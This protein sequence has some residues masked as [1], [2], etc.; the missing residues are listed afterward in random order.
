MGWG[1]QERKAGFGRFLA[2]LLV[3]VLLQPVWGTLAFADDKHVSAKVE[4]S[5]AAAARADPNAEFRVVVTAAADVKKTGQRRAADSVRKVNGRVTHALGIV[6]GASATLTGA[7]LLAL[8]NDKDV[9]AIV[10]DRSF[11][12]TF[13]PVAG[14]AATSSAPLAEIGAPATWS[15]LGLTG[16]GVTVAV[17][18]SGVAAHPDLGSRLVAAIDFTSSAPT[19]SPVAL[20]DPG[21]HGTHVAGLV[22]GD[23]TASGGLY[24]GVAPNASVVD[25]RVI[26]A[27]GTT[28]LSTVLR[29]LQWVLENRRVYNIRV[30]NLSFGA[31][32]RASYTEDLLATAA[33]VLTFA[34][35]V[36]VCAAG[37]A[38]PGTATIATPGSDPYVVTVGALDDAGTP[39]LLDDSIAA[40]SSRGPTA[41]DAIAKPDVVAPGRRMVSLRS[42]GSTLD[43]LFPDRRVGA[44]VDPAYFVLSGTS[45]AAPVVAGVVA[46]LLERDPTLTPGQIKYRLTSTATPLAF[47]TTSSAGAGLVNALAAA[48]SLDRS[49][50]RTA[51]RITNAFANEAFRPLFGQSL[52]WRDLSFNGGVDSGGRPWSEVD[53]NNVVWNDITW[54]NLAWEAFSWLDITW[55]TLTAATV[56]WESVDGLSVG[57]LSSGTAGGWDLVN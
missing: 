47:A 46:L 36:V 32:A 54:D 41:I 8:A 35:I 34:G 1:A 30:A 9:A 50:G 6:G 15:R 49:K 3:V 25:V 40:F 13:D 17:V 16:R 20:G 57:S 11:T 28:T 45:M 22:A 10:L 31:T 14:A 24:A 21:G 53:W 33:E 7:A 18:D 5:L 4:P 55:D 39:S 42:P 48:S 56:T 51:F 2:V 38:G 26:G 29:G 44:P 23:G 37:N 52:V 43:T 19:V 12:V 27:D